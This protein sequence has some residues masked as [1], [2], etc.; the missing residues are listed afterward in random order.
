MSVI[1]KLPITKN[2]NCT[3]TEVCDKQESRNVGFRLFLYAFVEGVEFFKICVIMVLLYKLYIIKTQNYDKITGV[4][5]H[6]RH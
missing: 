6:E 3:L 5:T 1:A 4:M 2:A